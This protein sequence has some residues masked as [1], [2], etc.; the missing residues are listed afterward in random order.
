[1]LSPVGPL[2]TA[3]HSKTNY[4]KMSELGLVE[5]LVP[6]LSIHVITPHDI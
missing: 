3:A 6:V 2:R 5:S 1:M 4:F